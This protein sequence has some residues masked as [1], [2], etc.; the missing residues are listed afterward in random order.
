M[1]IALDDKRMKHARVDFCCF[2]LKMEDELSGKS[3]L[4][5]SSVD[6]VLDK[7][8]VSCSGTHVHY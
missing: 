7:C 6:A 5:A 4:V 2:G 3:I 8:G 1:R